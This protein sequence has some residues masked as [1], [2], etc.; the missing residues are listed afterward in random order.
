[1]KK[2][3]QFSLRDKDVY[4]ILDYM[5]DFVRYRVAKAGYD[6]DKVHEITKSVMTPISLLLFNHQ[7][8][9]SQEG[10]EALINHARSAF[11]IAVDDP[12]SS[13]PV[14][15]RLSSAVDSY[16]KR[17]SFA[18][19][20]HPMAEPIQDLTFRISDLVQ[21][22]HD[23]MVDVRYVGD[24]RI[25]FYT[26]SRDESGQV[27]HDEV[28]KKP[29]EVPLLEMNV[30]D[31]EDARQKSKELGDLISEFK[32]IGDDK[33]PEANSKR[34]KLKS[35]NPF[36]H[37]SEAEG[38]DTTAVGEQFDTAR[39]YVDAAYSEIQFLFSRMTDMLNEFRKVQNVDVSTL[40]ATMSGVLE[41]LSEASTALRSGAGG[42]GRID[43]SQ[44]S[45]TWLPIRV[46]Q[47][48]RLP[49]QA[50]AI[51]KLMMQVQQV[52]KNLVGQLGSVSSSD[53]SLELLS[54]GQDKTEAQRTLEWE[55]SLASGAAN[56]AIK[57]IYNLLTDQVFW[58]QFVHKETPPE[59][60][61]EEPQEDMS[62]VYEPVPYNA[63]A[64]KP[65]PQA[66]Q[67]NPQWGVMRHRQDQANV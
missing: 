50:Y 67:F 66:P 13:L 15:D 34:T 1:M 42:Q 18:G 20:D 40:N 58:Y 49:E 3:A 54:P 36:S 29:I 63:P 57:D 65:Q 25:Q 39:S 22:Y 56:R 7:A 32:S 41:E 10:R 31:Q 44:F 37:I 60:P 16:S 47:Q 35:S 53:E 21:R 14:F 2:T 26:Y 64:P 48:K 52:L 55:M 11:E 17:D 23:P 4:Q 27:V 19:S 61:P 38:V 62:D 8:S 46:S 33:S 24:D 45:K 43:M 9:E 59:L 6:M 30:E 28:T 51:R 12:E 5:R